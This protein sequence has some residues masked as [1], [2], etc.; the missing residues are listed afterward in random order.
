MPLNE[1]S[2]VELR[3]ELA[4]AQAVRV[5]TWKGRFQKQD[6]IEAITNE[7]LERGSF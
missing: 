1:L 7:L 4:E 5:T 6:R 3:L 2:S